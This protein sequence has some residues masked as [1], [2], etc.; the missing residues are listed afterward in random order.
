MPAPASGVGGVST[1]LMAAR[2]AVMPSR[3]NPDG[4]SQINSIWAFSPSARGRSL[5]LPKTNSA[6][7]GS[8]PAGAVSRPKP[9]A[10]AAPA[11]R[12]QEPAF[13][14]S[15]TLNSA[16]AG[17]NW[18]ELEAQLPDGRRVFAVTNFTV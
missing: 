9:S 12:D 7:P 16:T 6:V 10:C 17:T 2:S 13:G 15:L 4:L 5:P 1:R 14:H 18:V 8:V 11:G 3:P